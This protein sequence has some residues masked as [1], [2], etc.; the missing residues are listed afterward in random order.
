MKRKEKDRKKG[1]KRHKGTQRNRKRHNETQKKKG[2]EIKRDKA[3][4]LD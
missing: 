1:S 4:Q 2:G 3:I